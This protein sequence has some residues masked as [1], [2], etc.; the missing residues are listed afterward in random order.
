MPGWTDEGVVIQSTSTD[1]YNAIDPNMAQDREGNLWLSFGSFW[2]GIKLIQL[3]PETMKPAADATLRSIAA[4]PGNTAIEAPFIIERN[5]YYYFTATAPEYGRIILRRAATIQGLASA[6]E[7]VIWQ[8]HASGIMGAHIWA[9]E[10][11]HVDG[12]WYIY[13]A[14]GSTRNVWAIRIYVLEN[15][16]TNP[17]EGT[18]EERDSSR[19]TGSPSPWMR[20]HSS[21]KAP[22]I[23]C[24]RNTI[25]KSAATPIFTSPR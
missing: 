23:W 11:H 5:G 20:R 1:N 6:S 17:L 19:P 18:W 4:K 14:A 15:A 9:P 2:S 21:T 8:K 3:D 25:R 22:G 13:F 16:A 10:L 24:G 7:T 12:K